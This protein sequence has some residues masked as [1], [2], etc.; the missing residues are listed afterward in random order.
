MPEDREEL[1]RAVREGR[2]VSRH[3]T[4]R[5]V[6][7]E[8]SWP[9]SG[10]DFRMRFLTTDSE[11]GWK[12]QSGTPSNGFV[13]GRE[14]EHTGSESRSSLSLMILSRKKVEN[15]PGRSGNGNKVGRELILFSIVNC[16]WCCTVLWWMM[17]NWFYNCRIVI[18]LS[19]PQIFSPDI[20]LCGWLG[21]KHRL[22]N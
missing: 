4:S 7:I 2:R 13:R 15:S 3:S 17:L 1:T 11:T 9:V 20:I 21:W 12:V 6:G 14:L 19:W 10:A 22:T 5:G 18:L 8:S 16:L